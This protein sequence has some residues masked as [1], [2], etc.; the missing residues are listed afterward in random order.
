MK[1]VYRAPLTI[2]GDGGFDRAP[3]REPLPE[4]LTFAQPA[5]RRASR[6]L[7]GCAGQRLF[8]PN[9]QGVDRIPKILTLKIS[10]RGC[11]IG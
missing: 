3:H 8:L 2:A 10:W 1:R 5:W 9:S 7:L 4:S 11:N 6:Q